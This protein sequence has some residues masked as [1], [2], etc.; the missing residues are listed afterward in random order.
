MSDIISDILSLSYPNPPATI[1]DRPM[2]FRDFLRLKKEVLEEYQKWW[3]QVD[4]GW[5]LIPN[6]DD[7]TMGHHEYI[8]G[9][10]DAPWPEA[11][12]GLTREDIEILKQ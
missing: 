5:E 6:E 8:K 10:P 4:G 7:P 11:L 3:S 2:S 1:W 12:K 9:N